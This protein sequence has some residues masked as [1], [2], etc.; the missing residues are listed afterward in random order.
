MNENLEEKDANSFGAEI[1][2]IN[3]YNEDIS[4]LLNSIINNKK[5]SN[6]N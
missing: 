4:R 5:L 6:F 1:I 3:N 2:W